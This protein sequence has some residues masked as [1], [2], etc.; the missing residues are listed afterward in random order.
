MLDILNTKIEQQTALST[1]KRKTL[2]NFFNK[3]NILIQI[4]IFKEQRNQFFKLKNKFETSEI[5]SLAAFFQAINTFYETEQL[6]KKKNKSQDLSSLADISNF[7]IKKFQTNKLKEK[8]EKLLNVWSVVQKMKAEN[9]SF[10]KIS[11][12]LRSKHRFDVSHSYIRQIWE[13]LND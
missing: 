10:R 11:K 3:Q 1:N 13:E 12:Y 7:A 4:D 8:R 6:Q 5:T 2:V 9:V